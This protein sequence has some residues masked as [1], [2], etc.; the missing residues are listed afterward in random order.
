MRVLEMYCECIVSRLKS[1]LLLFFKRRFD[2]SDGARH[3]LDSQQVS[4]RSWRRR[5]S[6]VSERRLSRGLI[7]E[8]KSC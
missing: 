2:R 5:L 3:R 8:G 1:G 4:K 6:G 7:L